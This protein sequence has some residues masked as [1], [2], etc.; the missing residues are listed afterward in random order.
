MRTIVGNE[1][2]PPFSMSL[3]KD[4]TEVNLRMNPKQAEMI[5]E[6]SRLKYGKD[7][8]LIEA[9]IQTRSNL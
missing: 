2:V 7:K 8:D 4:M 3:V 1:P 5:K 9:E 6:L